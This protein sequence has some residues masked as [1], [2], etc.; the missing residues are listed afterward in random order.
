MSSAARDERVPV[1]RYL[2]ETVYPGFDAVE[3]GLLDHLS[4]RARGNGQTAYTM[5]C[6]CGSSE[7][8]GDGYYY[9]GASGVNCHR[10]DKCAHG[11][12]ISLWDILDARGVGSNQDILR[13][14]CD[15]SGCAMPNE[16]N[17]AP[18]SPAMLLRNALPGL[19]LE[20]LRKA[21][22]ALAYL[23]ARGYSDEDIAGA[24][25]G[26]P[27]AG[28]GYY[29]G[30]KEVRSALAARGLDIALAE[31]WEV[32][33]DP[34]GLHKT[35]RFA[36]R[37]IGFWEQDDGSVRLWGRFVG[38]TK[39]RKYMFPAGAGVKT[40]P[41]L[42]RHPG[43]NPIITAEG[44]LTARAMRLSG[45]PACAIGGAEV[46]RAQA[47]F[48]AGEGVEQ[49]VFT[50]ESGS[51]GR[52]GLLKTIANCEPLG[53][54]VYG[55]LIPE[56]HDD[57]DTLRRNGHKAKILDIV[58]P[59]VNAGTHLARLVTDLTLSGISAPSLELS[60]RLLSLRRVAALLGP[61]SARHYRAGLQAHGIDHG[62]PRVDAL[63][64]LATLIELGIEEGEAVRRVEGRYGLR[65]AIATPVSRLET[66]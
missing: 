58:D 18:A 55:A 4:P 30:H 28:L 2:Q 15:A 11:L 48:L 20:F 43:K 16:N 52:A 56:G 41:Y 53:I 66:A 12:Y 1:G 25:I 42:Y 5:N 49:L 60:S 39:D 19:F 7:G 3:A 10:K 59:A 24:K 45:V 40:R 22:D 6:P 62:L 63:R 46:I 33:P 29:P 34:A 38:E 65:I 17:A 23:H 27:L 44:T 47:E 57:A 50:S 35:S 9:P 61:I 21:P 37:V 26:P 36:G 13:Q 8:K 14:L 32:L 31:E 64:D 51:A 54:T